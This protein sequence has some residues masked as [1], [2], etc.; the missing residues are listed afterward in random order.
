MFSEERRKKILE[1]LEKERRVLVKELAEQ[2]EVSI[3]S[4]RRDLSIMEDEQLL[5]R[6]HGG[7]IPLPSV[8]SMPRN[9]E[10]RFGESTP[11]QKQIAEKAAAYINPDQTVFIGGASI[12]YAMIPYLPRDFSFTVVTNSVEIAYKLREFENIHT[13]LIGGKMKSS[14]NI[15]DPLA[16]QFAGRFHYDLCFATGGGLTV[17]GLST[18][19]PEAALFHEKVYENSR[20]I[21]TLAEHTKVG[22]D[23]FTNMYPLKKLDIILTD[24]ETTTV[25]ADELEAHGVKVIRITNS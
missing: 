10:E 7:A 19:T 14:G 21:I 24:E 23:L 4:I 22:V 6:T 8:R 2:F 16:A 5:K 1:I 15:T 25:Q 17:R 12:H 3:D 13:Y 18:S 20:R 11:Y 9:N